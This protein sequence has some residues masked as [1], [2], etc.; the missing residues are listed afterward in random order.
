MAN[1]E[2]IEACI[3][4]AEKGISKLNNEVIDSVG[5]YTSPAIRHLLNNLGVYAENYLEVGVHRGATFT[6]ALYQ[7]HHI[8]RKVGIDNLSE[9]NEDNS[10]MVDF[11]K[12]ANRFVEDYIFIN[13]DCFAISQQDLGCKPDLYLYD[14]NHS[15]ESHD[16]ALTYFYDMLPDEFTYLVDDSN[17][18]DVRKGTEIGLA[19]TNLEVVYERHLTDEKWHNGFSIYILK[20]RA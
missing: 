16:Q 4:V 10:V 14:G 19:K 9:F 12:N 2:Q 15:L 1:I 13:K 6:S 20:K 17:W 18:K 5:G 11:L 8:K 3:R 7:N